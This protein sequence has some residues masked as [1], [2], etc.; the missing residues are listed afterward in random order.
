VVALFQV[1]PP[2]EGNTVKIT[3]FS[4]STKLFQL[5]FVRYVCVFQSEKAKNS[6]IPTSEG[7]VRNVL[8]M[9]FPGEFQ[10][11]VDGVAKYKNPLLMHAMSSLGM[12]EQKQVGNIQYLQ[13]CSFRH[14]K[15]Y[16]VFEL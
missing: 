4:V 11:R 10:R 3:S 9:L 8:F 2:G 15:H 13:A 5:V 12:P 7:E 6:K 16:F 14:N 1:P